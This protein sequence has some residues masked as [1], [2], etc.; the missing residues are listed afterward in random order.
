MRQAGILAAAGLIALEQ[1]PA[2]LH[3]DH[4]NA[5]F[6][7]EGL[8]QVPGIKIDPAKAQTNILI[9]DISGTG[10]KSDEFTRRLR[11]SGIFAGGVNPELVRFVTHMD[12]NRAGCERALEVVR[13]I[14]AGK[15]TAIVS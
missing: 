4:A 12:V 6:L 13:T 1:M 2:R 7:A 14:C 9:F 5:R 15:S 3:E 11:E 8:S 10:M